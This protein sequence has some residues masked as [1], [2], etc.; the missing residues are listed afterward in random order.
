MRSKRYIFPHLPDEEEARLR[1]VFTDP[2]DFSAVAPICVLGGS[3]IL[4]II[5]VAI[6]ASRLLY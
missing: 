2:G 6:S 4:A 3:A 5:G 1:R